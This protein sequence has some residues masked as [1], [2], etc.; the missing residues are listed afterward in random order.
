MIPTIL[1]LLATCQAPEPR[2]D[3]RELWLPP[4]KSVTLER[5]ERTV[6]ETLQAIRE[7]T[8]LELQVTG[9]DE[10]AK[11]TT[12][13]KERPVLEALHDLCRARGAGSVRVNEG[14]K[15]KGA[16]EL[17]GQGALPAAVCHWKQFR[18]EYV[19]I[20]VTTVRSLDSTNRTAS[21]T[22]S[23]TGQ[24]GTHPLSV[25]GFKP[26]E[27]VDDQGWSLLTA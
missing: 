1:A 24:P 16:I 13:W 3:T 17:D 27:I 19:D 6:G 14:R 22:L 5:A 7:Q 23:W 15:E 20:T 8:G 11:I 4:V 2:T 18:I 21:L 9:V 10:S 25:D 12:E 26:E